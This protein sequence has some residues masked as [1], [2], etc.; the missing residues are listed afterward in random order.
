MTAPANDSPAASYAM[1]GFAAALTAFIVWGGVT[2]LYL[3]QLVHIPMQEIIAQRILW[4]LPFA[5]LLLVLMDRSGE[6]RKAMLQPRTVLLAC[7]TACLITLN[8]ATYVWAISAH[9]T[10][11]AALGYYIN[12]LVN[13]LL[14]V[15]FLRERLYKAQIVAVVLA[16]A[17]VALLTVRAGGLPWISLVLAFSF[18][19]YGFIR[20][21]MPVGALQGFTLEILVLSVPALGFVLWQLMIGQDYI[22]HAP[23]L[24]LGL[25]MLAGPITAVPLILYALGARR[26]QYSTIGI[27]QYLSP[28][29]IFLFAVFAFGEPFTTVQFIAFSLIWAG[30]MIYTWSSFKQSR[31]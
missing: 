13:I 7:V 12:P 25:L 24:D 11:D 1:Q 28:T 27:M 31:A 21:T 8:W 26:L 4:S 22:T 20:K 19:F 29:L 17:A 5:L 2:P 9:R 18:G 14:G 3:K 6:L 10:V 30:L 16:V 15:L 23:T